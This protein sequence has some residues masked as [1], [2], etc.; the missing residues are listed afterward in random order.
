MSHVGPTS[1]ADFLQ[2]QYFLAEHVYACE[3]EHG[4]VFVDLH[5]LKYFGLDE[6]SLQFIPEIIG[7]WPSHR[8]HLRPPHETLPDSDVVHA[9]SANGL[10]SKDIKPHPYF[11][12]LPQADSD[13]SPNW[14]LSASLISRLVMTMRIA[15]TLTATRLALRSRNLESFL[16]QLSSA[17][18]T[19][20]NP[21]VP[22]LHKAV[23]ILSL[24]AKAR[25]W[26]YT[27]RD[28]CLLDSLL[29]TSV[30]R[31]YGFAAHLYI[32]VDL[33]PFTAHA[34][35]QIGPLLLDDTLSYVRKFTPILWV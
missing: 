22:S 6:D 19:P 20:E 25:V 29:L 26:F 14:N 3:L 31:K 23:E 11:K 13:C 34:W 17:L 33:N 5:S 2:K 12:S 7:D 24:F 16:A 9:L 4:A 21:T 27:A 10:L 1:T 30:L 28:Q 32:G 15:S 35:T 8:S 18:S